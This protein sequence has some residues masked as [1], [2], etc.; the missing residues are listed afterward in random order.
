MHRAH[1]LLV[2]L[3]RKPGLTLRQSY[4]R[5]GKPALM[6]YQRYAHAKQFKRANRALRS[7]RTHL[8]QVF[9]DIMR[10]TRNDANLRHIFAE[11]LSLGFRVRHQRQ[12]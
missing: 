1:E 12:N 6:A 3:A 5:V 10:K 4:A 7:L 2:R 11:P 9:R 8:G